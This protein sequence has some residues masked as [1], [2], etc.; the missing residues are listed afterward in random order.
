VYFAHGEHFSGRT[1][2]SL[3]F[4]RCAAR[5]DIQSW[6]RTESGCSAAKLGFRSAPERRALKFFRLSSKKHTIAPQVLTEFVRIIMER[7]PLR[8]SQF[9]SAGYDAATR[10]LEIEFSTG[11]IMQYSGVTRQ[12]ADDFMRASS[13]QSFYRDRIEEEY[14]GKKVG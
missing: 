6:L 14:N 13:P 10:T 2:E 4:K 12:V 5:A 9:K 11:T 7:K 1:L 3:I 8:S